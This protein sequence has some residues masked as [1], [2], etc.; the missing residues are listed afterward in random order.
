MALV[1]LATTVPTKSILIKRTMAITMV[2]VM[3]ATIAQRLS[4]QHKSIP[5]VFFLFYSFFIEKI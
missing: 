1:M 4:I 5:T 2:L 3:F